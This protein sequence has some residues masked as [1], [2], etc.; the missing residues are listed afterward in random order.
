MSGSYS[1]LSKEI[2]KLSYQIS[3][4]ILS[5]KSIITEYI[6]TG[7]L[8][9]IALTESINFVRGLLSPGGDMALDDFFAHFKPMPGSTLIDNAIGRYPFANQKTAANAIVTRPLTISLHMVC[10]AR[11]DGAYLT[12]LATLSALKATLNLHSTTGGTYIV[13]T[14][15]QIYANCVLLGLRDITQ[16][17]GNQVQAEYQWDFEQPLLTEADAI[18]AMNAQISAIASGAQ[19]LGQSTGASIISGTSL[20]GGAAAVLG[21]AQALGGAMLQQGGFTAP[22]GAVTQVPL[23]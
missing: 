2:F 22:L 13:A 3:P 7:L 23:I 21:G 8:P 6:P 14:P 12:K 18:V 17:T 4:I 20:A 11:G 15:G 1:T 16:S 5:G 19:T 9:I 10:P